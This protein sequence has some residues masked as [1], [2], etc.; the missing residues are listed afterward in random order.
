MLQRPELTLA[1]ALALGLPLAGPLSGCG[2]TRYY[3]VE[4][5]LSFGDRGEATPEVVTA[6]RRTPV[7]NPARLAI[8]WPS[9]CANETSAT[10]RGDAE[11]S[12]A[13]ASNDCALE[14]SAIERVFVSAG[15]QVVHWDS[16]RRRALAESTT[17]E[18]VA[19]QL[20][21]GLLL[22]VN[23]LERAGVVPG[24]DALWRREYYLSDA[25]GTRGPSAVVPANTASLLDRFAESVETDAVRE[26]RLA[27]TLD[28]TAVHAPTGEVSWFYRWTHQDQEN[29]VITRRLLAACLG[30]LCENLGTEQATAVTMNDGPRSGSTRA[31]SVQQEDASAQRVRYTA[32]MFETI[33]DLVRRVRDLEGPAAGAAP[34]R[35]TQPGGAQ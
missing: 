1:L 35:A 17:P 7:V 15:Y 13:L 16:I 24:S 9:H 31:L 21:I 23:S 32:L 29:Q 12:D 14:I 30:S 33:S 10:Q 2:A 8:V 5:A 28:V 4:T 19:E 25:S 6:Q 22:R 3:Y 27:V 34:Q 11:S 20:G 18:A 26:A